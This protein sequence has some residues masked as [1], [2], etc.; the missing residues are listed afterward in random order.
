MIC[1]V[2]H[3]SIAIMV[4]IATVGIISGLTST[5]ANCLLNILYI[6]GII[7][8]ASPPM[9]GSIFPNQYATYNNQQSMPR[10]KR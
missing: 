8:I 9:D 7:Y 3:G 6:R 4:I 1:S 2:Q 10:K 5:I